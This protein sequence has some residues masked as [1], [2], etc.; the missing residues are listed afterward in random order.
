MEKSY[1]WTGKIQYIFNRESN[2]CI[3]R[4]DNL[5]HGEQECQTRIRF[6]EARPH[7]WIGFEKIEFH[8]MRNGGNGSRVADVASCNCGNESRFNRKINWYRSWPFPWGD[9]IKFFFLHIYSDPLFLS[10][11]RLIIRF[12]GLS[13]RPNRDQQRNQLK[14][15]HAETFSSRFASIRY[16]FDLREWSWIIRLYTKNS[17]AHL[18]LN[19]ASF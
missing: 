7:N 11:P 1:N 14:K 4:G 8:A 17:S 2:E 6:R 18:S 19:A 10:F 12:N 3:E 15:Y 13:T 5:N 9:I 16:R